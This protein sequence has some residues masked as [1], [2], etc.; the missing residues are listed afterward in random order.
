M[1]NSQAG[2]GLYRR[3]ADA[4]HSPFPSNVRYS[5][6]MRSLY[7]RYSSA[8]FVMRS[9]RVRNT[10]A[11]RSLFIRFHSVYIRTVRCTFGLI[12]TPTR[13]S[14]L[15]FA[16]IRFSFVMYSQCI[17]YLFVIHTLPSAHYCGNLLISTA[18]RSGCPS[19]AEIFIRYILVIY[20]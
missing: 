5:S 18:D 15:T 16:D 12:S 4:I 3:N 10:F 13:A 17:R 14:A 9:V 20:S 6:A 1:K 19:S 11:I 8:V 2:G 7:V